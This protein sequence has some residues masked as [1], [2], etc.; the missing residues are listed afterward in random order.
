MAWNRVEMLVF[1]RIAE[2]AGAEERGVT[3]GQ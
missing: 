1:R 2:E 3:E